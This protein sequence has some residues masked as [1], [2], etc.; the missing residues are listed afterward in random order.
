MSGRLAEVRL[1]LEGSGTSAIAFE[2][3]SI[4]H[5]TGASEYCFLSTSVNQIEDV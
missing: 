1:Y 3:Q 4:S 5:S 2:I